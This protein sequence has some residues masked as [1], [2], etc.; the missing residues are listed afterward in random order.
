MARSVRSRPD[1]AEAALAVPSLAIAMGA[2]CRALS[3]RQGTAFD[4]FL[5][6]AGSANSVM[7][8]LACARRRRAALLHH[9]DRRPHR[10]LGAASHA[11][12]D[13]PPTWLMS[14]IFLPLTV[15]LALG[16]IRPI[17]GATVG[18]MLSFNMLKPDVET[19]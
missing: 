16:L 7:R 10:D 2:A 6:V 9:P 5:R 17:K 3:A 19:G 13:D 15:I 11:E 1:D 8:R 14:A 4:G 12:L 18:L